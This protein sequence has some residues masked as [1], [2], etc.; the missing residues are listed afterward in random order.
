[1]DEVAEKVE[2]PRLCL[3]FMHFEQLKEISLYHLGTRH[4]KST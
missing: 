1:M 2:A 3:H 4:F